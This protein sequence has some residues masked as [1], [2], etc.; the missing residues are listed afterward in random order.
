MLLITVHENCF[1]YYANLKHSVHYY[2]KTK[3]LLLTKENKGTFK[4]KWAIKNLACAFKSTANVKMN[5]VLV[6]SVMNYL[7]A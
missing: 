7:A 6:F 3:K 2:V 1:G 5:C 4:V